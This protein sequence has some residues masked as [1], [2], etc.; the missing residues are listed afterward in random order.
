[1]AVIVSLS[2]YFIVLFI[3][4]WRSRNAAHSQAFVIGNRSV[5]LLGTVASQAGGSLDGSGLVI[6]IMFGILFGYG[7]AWQILGLMI[8]FGLLA[9]QGPRIRA[10]AAEHKLLNI[11]D[12]LR[13]RIGPRTEKLSTLLSMTTSWFA[14]AGQLYVTGLIFHAATGWPQWTGII[15]G[16]GV[17][18]LYTII[19]GYV[20]LVRTDIFQ[21]FAVTAILAVAFIFGQ[22]PGLNIAWSQFCDMGIEW[23]L[24]FIL[25]IAFIEYAIPDTWQ[26]IFSAR[27]S[28]VA[29]YGPALGIPVQC[30]YML[31]IIT[32]GGIIGTAVGH[33]DAPNAFYRYLSS[34]AIPSWVAGALGV[35]AMAKVMSA[36][37]TR[38]YVFISMLCKDVL[39]ID[40]DTD[41]AHYVHSTR[42]VT[43]AYFVISIFVAIFI[44]D[45]VQYMFDVA[46]VIGVLAPALFL[47]VYAN[48]RMKHLDNMTCSVLSLGMMTFLTMLAL[49]KLTT[50][51]MTAIPLIVTTILMMLAYFVLRRIDSQINAA[52]LV[53]SE[54][55]E[56][57]SKRA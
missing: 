15:L 37:D 13:V 21:W 20:T 1:M 42:L 52:P 26:R 34:S 11:T 25:L 40:P 54:V 55:S 9:W 19:G 8:A 4:S 30:I 36:L 3:I 7:A 2:I 28:N 23:K 18:M 31:G 43:F 47:A 46:A 14:T 16:G 41:L 12:F 35:L 48:P 53:K 38:A 56:V 51:L 50:I 22:K 39:K 57:A 32:L 33:Y 49:G 10:I 45:I 24:G 44:S 27:D 17:V 6:T 29:R 5:S